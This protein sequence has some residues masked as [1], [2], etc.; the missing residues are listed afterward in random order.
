MNPFHW[1][2][3]HQPACIMFCVIG[4]II[5]L[6]F[7]WFQDPFYQLCHTSISGQWANCTRVFFKWLP[8]LALYWPLPMFGALI[9]G[10]TFYAV[11]LLRVAN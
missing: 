1:R 2:R 10:L 3:E 8:N 6:L 7:A 4:A 11:R 5:G 9:A